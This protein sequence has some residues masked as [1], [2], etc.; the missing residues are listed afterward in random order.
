MG[1]IIRN[2]R[3]CDEPMESSPFT[4]CPKCLEDSNTIR[5]TMRKKPHLSLEDIS[6]LTNVP[7]NKIKRLVQLGLSKAGSTRNDHKTKTHINE[8][9]TKRR[10]LI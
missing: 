1:N 6:R 4:M 10:T 7:L 5:T 3:L 8:S 2:C 9:I